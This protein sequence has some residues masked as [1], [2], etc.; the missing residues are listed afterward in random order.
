MERSLITDEFLWMLSGEELCQIGGLEGWVVDLVQLGL[1]VK[2]LP[3][4]I[5]S[6]NIN[7]LL[8]VSLD[9]RSQGQG[10]IGFWI[11]RSLVKGGEIRREKRD[12]MS[13]PMKG[14]GSLERIGTTITGTEIETKKGRE[15]GKGIEIEIGR[16]IV[17]ETVTMTV[18]ELVVGTRKGTMVVTMTV[19][20][21]VIVHVIGIENEKETMIK[22]VMK[23]KVVVIFM[24]RI[25][26]MAVSQ[27]MAGKGLAQGR[28]M[29]NM[30]MA[31]NGTKD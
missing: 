14:P 26:N 3:R 12:L 2:N 18:I 31:K 15:T 25:L 13:V 6:G 21:N 24:T 19:S 10:M 1:E 9:Q 11:G 30:T 16:K 27:S 4:S 29:L 20:M 28:E 7:N 17:V 8:Q 23:E 22:L 5:L